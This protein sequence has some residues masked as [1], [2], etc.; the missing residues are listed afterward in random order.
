MSTAAK[1][2]NSVSTLICPLNTDGV[3]IQRVYVVPTTHALCISNGTTGTDYGFTRAIKDDNGVSVLVGV[4][5]ADFTTPVDIYAD[6]N[7]N[8]LTKS[9]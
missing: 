2:V 5:S 4:S 9:T 1:D 8:I 7:G 3:T 6:N